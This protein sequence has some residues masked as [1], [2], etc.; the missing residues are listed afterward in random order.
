MSDV[1]FKPSSNLPTA[2]YLWV[3]IEVLQVN[4]AS[5]I[6]NILEPRAWK[7]VLLN[8]M[9]LKRKFWDYPRVRHKQG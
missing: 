3:V 9:L 5:K 4:T 2:F 1:G 6:W 7:V 8:H